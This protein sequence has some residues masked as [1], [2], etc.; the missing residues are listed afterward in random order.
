MNSREHLERLH[1]AELGAPRPSSPTAVSNRSEATPS[2]PRLAGD[3]SLAWRCEC[4]ELHPRAASYCPY[5]DATSHYSVLGAL[6]GSPA[7]VAAPRERVRERSR[8]RRLQRASVALAISLL[9]AAGAVAAAS[10]RGARGRDEQLVSNARLWSPDPVVRK[11]AGYVEQ[12]RGLR[13]LRPVVVT[14]L[15][16]RAFRTREPGT[17]LDLATRVQTVT[18]RALGLVNGDAERA[19]ESGARQADVVGVYDIGTK[20]IYVRADLAGPYLRFVLVHELTHALQDQYFDLSRPYGDD[21]DAVRAAISLVE[22]DAQRVAESYLETLGAGD[23]DALQREALA[24]QDE[25]FQGLYLRS[26][27]DFPYSAGAAFVRELLE[28]GGQA[29][30]DAAFRSYPISTEQV[31][32]VERYLRGDQPVA[33]PEPPAPGAGVERGVLGEFELV[34]VLAAGGIDVTTATRAGEG[35]GG[36]S[37]VTWLSGGRACVRVGIVM[38]T[39][40]DTDRLAAALRRWTALRRA[41]ASVT[42]ARP[43]TLTACERG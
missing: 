2:T 13:F 39:P 5:C 34:S 36:A 31:L 16:E 4:G 6:L 11:L 22:G 21:G 10:A 12:A 41:G 25:L 30:L 40:T 14:R 19:A 27:D 1:T 32:H 9:V 29:G 28:R 37:Y 18:L 23:V 35:W 15:S 26:A 7:P 42:G 38:D 8:Q 33:V 43:L 17:L 20:Q 3:E 24:R